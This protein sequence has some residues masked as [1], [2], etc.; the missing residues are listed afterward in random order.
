[1]RE[2]GHI[3]KPRKAMLNLIELS[4]IEFTIH[5][6]RRTF[7][8]TAESLDILVYALKRLFNH[9]MNNDLT[10]ELKKWC[11]FIEE[12]TR[13]TKECNLNSVTV[14]KMSILELY[15]DLIN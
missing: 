4:D 11:T 7:I 14:D 9:K 8:T 2:P 10:S 3:V 5:D 13:L 6:L 15:M 12:R 1:M